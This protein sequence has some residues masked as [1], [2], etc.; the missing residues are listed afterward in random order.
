MD[1]ALLNGADPLLLGEVSADC[2]LLV[3][4]P[5]DCQEFRIYAF[6]RRQDHGRWLELEARTNARRLA[7][8]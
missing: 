2:Q 5:A 1:L 7:A 4:D 8:L 3:G 6:K